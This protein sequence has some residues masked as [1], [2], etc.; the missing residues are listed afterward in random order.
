MAATEGSLE[1]A[2]PEA[3][4]IFDSAAEFGL[5]SSEI[6]EATMAT[7]ERM[8]SE[9]KAAY[10]DELSGALARCLLEKERRLGVAGNSVTE[11]PE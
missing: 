1:P 10:I 7:L 2:W 5:E 4:T 8:P 3:K 9:M 11:P 6:L